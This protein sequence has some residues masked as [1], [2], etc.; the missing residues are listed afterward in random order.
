M[1][2][3]LNST[4]TVR[5]TN[6]GISILSNMLYKIISNE[7]DYRLEANEFKTTFCALMDIFG[8]YCEDHEKPVFVDNCIEI[9][10]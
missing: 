8:N 10:E 2:F 3:Y 9:E 6:Y 7:V 4:I 5:L 1:K